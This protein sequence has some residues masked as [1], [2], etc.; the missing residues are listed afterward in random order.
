MYYYYFLI[1]FLNLKDLCL[2]FSQN[3]ANLN[4]NFIY[5]TIIII[6]IVIIKFFFRLLLLILILI[7]QWICDQGFVIF[8]NGKGFTVCILIF[9]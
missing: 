1:F 9:I 3:F 6:F 5:L 2:Y 4:R 7:I 8:F